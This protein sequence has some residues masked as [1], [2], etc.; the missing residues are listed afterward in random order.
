VLAYI[1]KRIV[2]GVLLI[3][4]VTW[5]TFVIFTILPEERR[6][7]ATQ[8]LA[9]P[10]IQQQ[11]DLEGS[12]PEQYV[13]FLQHV[14]LH[15]D[16]G[17]SLRQPVEVRDEILTALPVTASLLLG[18]IVMWLI[19]G[20]TIGFLSALRP[21]SLLDK[22]LMVFV[23][24]GVSAHPVWIGLML[25][26]FLGY[27]WDIFPMA[28]YCDF[29][30]DPQS[31][32]LCGGPR[33]WAYHLV[34]PWFAFALLFAALY[35]R[36]I[37]ASMLEV[38]NEDYI[39]TA[40]G[41]GAGEL[42]IMRKHVLRNALLPVVT[43]LGMDVGLAFAGAIFIESVFQLPGVGQLLFRALPGLDLPMIMGI[44]FLV[45]VAVVVLNMIVDILYCLIDPRIS[46]KGGSSQEASAPLRR[47]RLRA[48][49]V[50]ESATE[51]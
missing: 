34:L 47:R 30:Y 16:F 1:L 10:N 51:A 42:R 32:N 14:V 44:V 4:V 9:T 13:T 50:T 24:I 38:K 41:K 37:R 19:L 33:F 31:S 20:F 27:Q 22:G 28:G 23:L 5:I 15:A 6:G 36:M 8:G 46:L 2:W 12:L 35:A 17:E 26:Y 49:P 21:R 45:S 7:Q 48:Q 43:M 11:F 18:G 29:L 25:S 39:R 40:Y 3:C